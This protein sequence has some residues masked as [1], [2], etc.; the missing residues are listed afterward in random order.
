MRTSHRTTSVVLICCSSCDVKVSVDLHVFRIRLRSSSYDVND[1]L[2]CRTPH[3][4]D[5]P[6]WLLPRAVELVGG[7]TLLSR[8][9]IASETTD[10]RLPSRPQST[11]TAPCAYSLPIPLRVG[12]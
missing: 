4:R 2:G 5:V 3:R 10:L 9:L 11:V 6:A 1:A 12:G 7:Y 8:R